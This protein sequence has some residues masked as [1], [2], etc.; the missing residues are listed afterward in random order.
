MTLLLAMCD[1]NQ[2]TRCA[3][4]KGLYHY[5]K[6][7]DDFSFVDDPAH[8]QAFSLDG[9]FSL[10]RAKLMSLM[11]PMDDAQLHFLHRYKD[12]WLGRR[13]LSY[14]EDKNM[15]IGARASAEVE[16]LITSFATEYSLNVRRDLARNSLVNWR[17]FSHL[18]AE[19]LPLYSIAAIQSVDVDLFLEHASENDRLAAGHLQR[20][21]RNSQGMKTLIETSNLN[22]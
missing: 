2:P 21:A 20:Y 18:L 9:S 19:G 15:V 5:L 1:A 11:Q 22:F 17:V 10:V 4:E 6:G 3:A 7:E 16:A 8:T 13:M 12:E 14:L